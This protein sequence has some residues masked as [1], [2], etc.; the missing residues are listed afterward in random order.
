MN[1][2]AALTEA[3]P[4]SVVWCSPTTLVVH[5]WQSGGA[6]VVKF[7]IERSYRPIRFPSGVLCVTVFLLLPRR[8][9]CGLL[10]LAC[11]RP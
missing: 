9:S 1:E 6:D 3:P 2:V 7:L 5:G 4:E 10:A 8:C 11:V